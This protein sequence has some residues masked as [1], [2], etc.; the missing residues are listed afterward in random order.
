M[1]L[2]NFKDDTRKTTALMKNIL[3]IN[4]VLSLLLMFSAGGLFCQVDPSAYVMKMWNEYK[5]ADNDSLRIEKLSRLAFF[6]NDYLDDHMLTD[7]LSEQAIQLAETSHRP[8]LLLLACNRYVESNDLDSY[9]KKALGY[10]LLNSSH[11]CNFWI[12][13]MY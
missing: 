11:K 6:Y 4:L 9:Y 13:Q 10:A 3:P 7:S 5:A 1:F 12:S 2:V 8:E